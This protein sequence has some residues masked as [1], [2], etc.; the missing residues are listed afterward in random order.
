MRNL[1]RQYQPRVVLLDM[2][3]V[4]DMEYSALQMLIEG[5]QRVEKQG[6]E[7]WLAGLSP[8]VLENVRHSGLADSLGPNRLLFNTRVAIAQ[9]QQEVA[10]PPAQQTSDSP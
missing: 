7:L 5:Q 3:R 2:S 1:M 10:P 4:P 9:F 8:R 6:T